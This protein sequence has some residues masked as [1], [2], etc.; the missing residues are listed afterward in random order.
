MAIAQDWYVDYYN[1]IICHASYWIYY[2][3]LA[4]G[5]YTAGETITFN[6]A[7]T[8]Y[9][10][11]CVYDNGVDRMNVVYLSGGTITATHT[12]E[13]S[14]ATVTSAVGA[15]GTWNTHAYGMTKLRETEL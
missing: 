4:G 7:G 8:D 2:T 11:I 9:T 3:G 10:A 15:T 1:K 14:T 13:D 12:M 6:S 5:T